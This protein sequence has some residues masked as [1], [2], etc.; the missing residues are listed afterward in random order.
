[1]F[2]SMFKPLLLALALGFC[3]ADAGSGF[4]V[5]AHPATPRLDAVAMKRLY[6]GRLVEVEGVGVI[7]I[8]QAMGRTVRVQFMETVLGQA[9]DKYIA[10]WTVRRYIG[11]GAPPREMDNDAAVISYVQSTPGAVGYVSEEVMRPGLNV[12]TFR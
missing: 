10:Y 6:M 2:K 5:I 1:M 9:D 12:Q 3:R 4:V 8:N 11:K 7:P